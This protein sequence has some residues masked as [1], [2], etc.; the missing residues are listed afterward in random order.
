LHTATCCIKFAFGYPGHLH[1]T[2]TSSSWLSLVEG[3]FAQ[4]TYRRLKKGAFSSVQHLEDEIGIWAEGWNEDP[5]PFIE[6]SK[7]KRSSPR[8]GE[9]A[10]HCP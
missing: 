1:F 10:R 2:P 4:L 3:W 8:S 6:R 5:K 9:G 7:P